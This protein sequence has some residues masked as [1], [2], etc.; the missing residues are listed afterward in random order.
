MRRHRLVGVAAAVAIGVGSVSVLTPTAHAD[1]AE[2]VLNPNTGQLVCKVTT[3]TATTKTT[4]GGSSGGGGGAAAGA[5]S[6]V[7]FSLDGVKAGGSKPKPKPILFNKGTP[8]AK[9]GIQTAQNVI[10]GGCGAGGRQTTTTVN[11]NSQVLGK[12]TGGALPLAPCAPPA[13]AAPAAPAAAAAPVPPIT[14]QQAAAAAIAKITFTAAA[15]GMGP[16]HHDN[17]LADDETGLPFDGPVG[18]PLW[19]WAAGGDTNTRAVA[20]TQGG[21][22]VAITVKFTSTTWSMGDGTTLTCGVGTPW[23]KSQ[24]AQNP[25]TP[26]PTCGHAYQKKGGYTVTATT[27]WAIHWAAGGQQG[28]IVKAIGRSRPYQVGELQVLVQ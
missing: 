19:L 24:A 20:D 25:G 8:A 23:V 17:G 6:S 15:P 3:T 16:D 28:D 21:M 4:S 7:N 1:C 26:S 12:T 18:F 2:T 22:N 9:S 10:T 27:H 5:G 11:Q 14:P 13:A